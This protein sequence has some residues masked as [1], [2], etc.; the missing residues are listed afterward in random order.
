[1]KLRLDALLAKRGLA[2]SSSQAQHMIKSGDVYV[3]QQQVIKSGQKYFDDAE[4]EVRKPLHFVSRG[5]LKLERALAFFPF[6]AKGAVALDVGASTGGFTDCLLQAG[7]QKVY[8][9]DV[10]HDQLHASLRSDGRVINLEYT[11]VY[12]LDEDN[13][14]ELVD[15]LVMDTS[16]ISLE[17]VLPCA[18]PFLKPGGWCAA[19]IKPQFELESN[20]LK[21]GIVRDSLVRQGVV[22]KI[23][24]FVEANLDGV[25]VLGVTES[26]IQGPKGN[27]EFLLGLQRLG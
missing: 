1:M 26:P 22:D 13:V 24:A 5:G 16:F 10:G 9:V 18:W 8:A 27:V 2:A 12:D 21:K 23:V 15:A 17:K 4:L 19:L 25:K 20:D 14:P 3:N 11:H 7:A 6:Q